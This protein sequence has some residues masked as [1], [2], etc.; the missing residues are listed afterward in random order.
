M[1][2]VRIAKHKQLFL[3]TKVV[4]SGRICVG[5]LGVAAVIWKTDLDCYLSQ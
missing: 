3:F 1:D 4:V 5:N 2:I